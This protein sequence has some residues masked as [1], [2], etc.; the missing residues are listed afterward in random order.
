[1][2]GAVSKTVVGYSV[3]RGFESLP[4][5][6]RAANHARGAVSRL[7][8]H[9]LRWGRRGSAR[10]SRTPALG[11]FLSLGFPSKAC[12]RPWS[13]GSGQPDLPSPSAEPAAA[14]KGRRPDPERSERVDSRPSGGATPFRRVAARLVGVVSRHVVHIEAKGMPTPG[15]IRRQRQILQGVSERYRALPEDAGGA[16]PQPI[17]PI[18]SFGF[19]MRTTPEDAVAKLVAVL[20][21]VDPEWRSFV[22][23]WD[24]LRGG[25]DHAVRA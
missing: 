21:E 25:I 1:L 17:R 10:A 2:N 13:A 15:R 19:S 7:F 23:V 20:D 24:G 9:P 8:A 22:Q 12:G 11:R 14:V 6:L 4:L 5:R 3:H 16:P 18:A